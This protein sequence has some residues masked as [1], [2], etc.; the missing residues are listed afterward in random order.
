MPL[1]NYGSGIAFDPSDWYFLPFTDMS[2]FYGRPLS[3][4]TKVADAPHA[5]SWLTGTP[6]P[7]EGR[8]LWY[9][10]TWSLLRWVNDHFGP[11]F[12]PDGERGIQK[13][14]VNNTLLGLENLADVV[15]V[16]IETLLA[17]WAATLYLDDRGIAGLPAR[18]DFPSWNLFDI[19]QGGALPAT[20]RLVPIVVLFNNSVRDVDVRAAST[21]YFLLSGAVSAPTAIRVRTQADLVL[22]STVQVFVVRIQ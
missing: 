1:Q 6:A 10:V 14:L 17:E 9:G 16:P 20:S 2:F 5:C 15:G 3:G 4:T 13:A 8:S 18:L 19:F 11:G 7:C 22:P 12:L 21:A